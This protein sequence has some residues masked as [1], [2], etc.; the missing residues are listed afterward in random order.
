MIHELSKDRFHLVADLFKDIEHNRGVITAVLNGPFR[1]RVFVDDP[2]N[3]HSA[4]VYPEGFFYFVASPQPNDGFLQ[5]FGRMLFEDWKVEIVELFFFPES[6]S[7]KLEL[8]IGKRPYL[9]FER[10]DYILEHAA[11]LSRQDE[12]LGQVPQGMESVPWM[13]ASWR[14]IRSTLPYGRH[15]RISWSKHS[16]TACL[17]KT[18]SSANAWWDC[19]QN[20]KWNSTCGRMRCTAGRVWRPL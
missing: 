6:L 18:G 3:P 10:R 17:R 2:E 20:T 16:A 8:I 14:S 19:A 5:D 1:A 13:L 7:D 11:F 15:S 12:L 4:V 9:R